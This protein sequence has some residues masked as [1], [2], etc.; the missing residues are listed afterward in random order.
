M[1]FQSQNCILLWKVLGF[2]NSITNLLQLRLPPFLFFKWKRWK[3]TIFQENPEKSLGSVLWLEKNRVGHETANT[4]IFYGRWHHNEIYISKQKRFQRR[5]LAFLLNIFLHVFGRRFSSYHTLY[6]VYS[7]IKR[8]IILKG[9]S[10]QFISILRERESTSL[11][12]IMLGAKLL[13]CMI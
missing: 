12:R 7:L 2:I 10:K 3:N 11:Q 13:R 6:S 5:N 8:Y 4:H 9:F 1:V